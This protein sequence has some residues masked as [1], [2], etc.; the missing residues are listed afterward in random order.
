MLW[1]DKSLPISLASPA[2]LDTAKTLARHKEGDGWQDPQKK[3]SHELTTTNLGRSI[4]EPPGRHHDFPDRCHDL[5]W[6]GGGRAWKW[7]K[8]KPPSLSDGVGGGAASPGGEQEQQQHI[9]G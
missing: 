3:E 6:G 5:G 4:I 1:G 8:I 7:V 9:K 2:P